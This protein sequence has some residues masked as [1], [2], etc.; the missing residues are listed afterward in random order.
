MVG[1]HQ[2]Y[3]FQSE[4]GIRWVK[5]VKELGGMM[6]CGRLIN[7]SFHS[8]RVSHCCGHDFSESAQGLK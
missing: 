7:L 2:G 4:K 5:N 3:L 8:D 6:L 1:S